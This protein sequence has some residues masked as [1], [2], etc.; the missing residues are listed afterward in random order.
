M[1]TLLYGALSNHA[2][3]FGLFQG[4]DCGLLYEPRRHRFNYYFYLDAR[5][6]V[7]LSARYYNY[8]RLYFTAVQSRNV[9]A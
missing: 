5:G 7:L 9:R 8:S 6:D 4:E 3:Q 2:W 1:G